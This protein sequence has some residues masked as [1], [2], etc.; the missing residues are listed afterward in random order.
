MFDA[1]HRR[2]VVTVA[3]DALSHASIVTVQAEGGDE[4]VI[5]FPDDPAGLPYA[6]VSALGARA[7]VVDDIHAARGLQGL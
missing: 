7:P 5:T 4:V 1:D 3:R 6:R 2:I